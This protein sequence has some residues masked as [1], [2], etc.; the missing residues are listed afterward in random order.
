MDLFLAV[1]GALFASILR[2]V[3]FG[4]ELARGAFPFFGGFDLDGGGVG[5]S[6]GAALEAS[7]TDAGSSSV[8]E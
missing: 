1:G 2:A 8:L 6:V 4:P 5:E 7:A 3:F